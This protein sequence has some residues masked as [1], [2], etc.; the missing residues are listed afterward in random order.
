MV[1][2]YFTASVGLMCAIAGMW[3]NRSTSPEAKAQIRLATPILSLRRFPE[4][5]TSELSQAR[6][7]VDLD[8]F[9]T[10]N[11]PDTSCLIVEIRGTRVA[12]IHPD[13]LYTPAST[14]KILTGL[15]AIKKLGAAHTF[16]TSLTSAAPI[17][18]GTITGDVYLVGGGDPVLATPDYNAAATYQPTAWTN[19]ETLADSIAATGVKT[20]TGAIIGDESRYDTV[21]KLASWG[22]KEFIFQDH[23]GPMSALGL[24]DGFDSNSTAATE[25]AAF[26]AETMKQLLL[27]RGVNI[28]GVSN[29]GTAPNGTKEIAGI[30]SPPL[31]DLVADMIRNSDNMTAELLTKELDKA[32]GGAGTTKTGALKTIADLVAMGLPVGKSKLIDGSGLDSGN[33]VTCELLH[34]ALLLGGPHGPIGDGLSV[35]GRNGTLSKSM[36]STAAE[37]RVRAKTGSIP[38]I[39]GLVGYVDPSSTRPVS[40]PPVSFAFMLNGLDG[41]DQRILVRDRLGETLASYPRGFD[42]AKITP[43]APILPTPPKGTKKPS[44]TTTKTTTTNVSGTVAITIP[45]TIAP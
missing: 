33:K 19:I 27:K 40:T 18:N 15:V 32:S 42:L 23:T 2:I 10:K 12:E 24:N 39:V 37:S 30:D 4:T 29:V 13:M 8:A 3:L 26:T 38:G 45:T 20:I 28:V 6:L 11:V 22:F 1:L 34:A 17:V 31:G 41:F 5:T 25:P 9:I 44:S 7:K 35:A 36:L 14:E 16:R 43:L 21:R